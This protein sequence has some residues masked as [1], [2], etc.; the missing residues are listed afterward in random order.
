MSQQVLRKGT[1]GN[2]VAQLQ[3]L[4]NAFNKNTS[5]T[6]DG[7]FGAATLTAVKQ[8]QQSA[9]LTAD[10]IVGT[11]TWQALSLGTPLV[12]VKT[13]QANHSHSGNSSPQGFLAEIAAKY[14]GVKETGNNKAGDSKELLAIFTS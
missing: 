2:Q 11:K 6:V 3:K 10:G 7:D 1:K 14:I 5:L 12:V 9:G 13:T 4:L 8:F